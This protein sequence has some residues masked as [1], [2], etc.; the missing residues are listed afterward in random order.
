MKSRANATHYTKSGLAFDDGTEIPA[1]VIVWSTGFEMNLR[2]DIEAM[3]GAEVAKK[4]DDFFGVDD[5]GEVRG[6]WKLQRE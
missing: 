6:A 3:L 2:K 4:T 1:D 5:E